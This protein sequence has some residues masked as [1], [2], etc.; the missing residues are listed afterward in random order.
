M[1]NLLSCLELLFSDIALKS[2]SAIRMF[3]C[4]N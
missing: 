1:E 4:D 2:I 3:S